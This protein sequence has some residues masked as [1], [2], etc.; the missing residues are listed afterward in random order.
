MDLFSKGR[1]MMPIM[2]RVMPGLR[3]TQGGL[4]MHKVTDK[5]ILNRLKREYERLTREGKKLS[6]GKILELH[7]LGIYLDNEPKPKGAK[8]EN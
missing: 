4:N 2:I 7:S 1:D 3:Y 5:R 8:N 6:P